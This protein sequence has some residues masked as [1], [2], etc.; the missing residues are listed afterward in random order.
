MTAVLVADGGKRLMLA[1]QRSISKP[2]LHGYIG[3]VAP[4]EYE[5][6]YHAQQQAKQ[7]IGNQ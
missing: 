3:D 1:R 2:T 7:L 5:D 6:T 4:A